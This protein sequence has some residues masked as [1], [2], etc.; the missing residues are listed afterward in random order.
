MEPPQLLFYASKVLCWVEFFLDLEE[1][2]ENLKDEGSVAATD[3]VYGPIMIYPESWTLQDQRL[4]ETR[5]PWFFDL[6]ETSSEGRTS[7]TQ[8][9]A[10]VWVSQA[11][12]ME[13][14]SNMP[15]SSL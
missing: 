5:H 1:N 7:V 15:R 10:L 6:Q 12:A 8:V 14:S 9:A 4:L 2:V 3:G 11:L 13:N